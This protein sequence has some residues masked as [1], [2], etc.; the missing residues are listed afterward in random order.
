MYNGAFFVW[1]G[2]S[3]GGASNGDGSPTTSATPQTTLTCY[4]NN[5]VA[6]AGQQYSMGTLADYGRHGNC[7]LSFRFQ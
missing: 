5:N 4:D 3:A 2:G 1:A 6:G 7:A